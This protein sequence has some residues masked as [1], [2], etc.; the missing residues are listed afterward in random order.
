MDSLSSF[1]GG[2]NI[3]SFL[4]LTKGCDVDQDIYQLQEIYLNTTQRNGLALQFVKEQTPE[5]CIYVLRSSVFSQ[6]ADVIRQLYKI[7]DVSGGDIRMLVTNAIRDI[8][9]RKW[10]GRFKTLDPEFEKLK[11]LLSLKKN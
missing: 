11:Q 10:G 6:D 2:M 3:M 7:L 9:C 8:Q 1:V 4:N 5:I